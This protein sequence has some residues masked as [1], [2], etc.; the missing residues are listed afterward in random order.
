MLVYMIE[1]L[2]NVNFTE[3]I[4]LGI[5]KEYIIKRGFDEIKSLKELLQKTESLAF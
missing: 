5:T 3:T 4:S 1:E 2:L